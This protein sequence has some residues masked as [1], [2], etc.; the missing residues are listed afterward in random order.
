MNVKLEVDADLGLVWVLAIKWHGDVTAYCSE[1]FCLG[2]TLNPIDF[3]RRRC[4][5]TRS[6]L[7]PRKGDGQMRFITKIPHCHEIVWAR[8]SLTVHCPGQN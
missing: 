2:W 4:W 8:D 1:N 7:G 3:G 6:L 5:W